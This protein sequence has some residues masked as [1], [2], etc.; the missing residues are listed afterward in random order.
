MCTP[1]SD[2][3]WLEGKVASFKTGIDGWELT[4]T[5]QEQG[6]WLGSQ[7]PS[8]WDKGERSEP[9]EGGRPGMD[10]VSKILLRVDHVPGTVL[11]PGGKKTWT[12]LC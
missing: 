4:D 6:R 9:A 11:D 8:V 1:P 5:T 10:L 2:L 7:R 12:L 3:G